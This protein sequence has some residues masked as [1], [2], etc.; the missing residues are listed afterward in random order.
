M[1]VYVNSSGAKGMSMH[2]KIW[3]GDESRS[4]L[5]FVKTTY[6]GNSRWDCRRVVSSSPQNPQNLFLASFSQQVSNRTG[7]SLIVDGSGFCG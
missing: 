5:L 4:F 3:K 2:G 6:H 7:S 1:L